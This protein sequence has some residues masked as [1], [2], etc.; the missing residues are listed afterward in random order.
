MAQVAFALQRTNMT[1]IRIISRKPKFSAV[2]RS[3]H[4]KRSKKL[5]HLRTPSAPGSSHKRPPSENA[6]ISSSSLQE[7][8]QFVPNG[9]E[10]PFEIP[11]RR[12][13]SFKQQHVAPPDPRQRPSTNGQGFAPKRS[14]DSDGFEL[15]QPSSNLRTS[16]M[17]DEHT[18]KMVTVVRGDDEDFEESGRTRGGRTE[19]DDKWRQPRRQSDRVHHTSNNVTIITLGDDSVI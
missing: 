1:V 10:I 4:P 19:M 18:G 2:G 6:C 11:A 14:P 17:R 5:I 3:P 8:Q 7:S 16:S 15:R 12:I 9:K 13:P